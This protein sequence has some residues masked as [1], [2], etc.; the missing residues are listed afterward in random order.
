MIGRWLGGIRD[1]R[2][3]K[4]RRREEERKVYAYV[5]SGGGGES[6]KGGR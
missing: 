1:W 2:V 3:Y 5:M 6:D 4:E